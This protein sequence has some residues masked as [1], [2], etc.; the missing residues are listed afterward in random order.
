[1]EVQE[2]EEE[3]ESVLDG[4]LR[5]LELGSWEGN[6]ACWLAS[7]VCFRTGDELVCVDSFAGG[8]E[9]CV[10]TLVAYGLIH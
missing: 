7:H 10:F 8:D 2:L 5:V 1:M 6:S 3:E 9:V 4:G